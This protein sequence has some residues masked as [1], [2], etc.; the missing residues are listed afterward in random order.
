MF[1]IDLFNQRSFSTR[2]KKEE[3]EKKLKQLLKRKAIRQTRKAR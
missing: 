2:E 1:L 3:D